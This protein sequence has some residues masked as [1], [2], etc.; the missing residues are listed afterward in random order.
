MNIKEVV[1]IEDATDY[2][3][4]YNLLLDAARGSFAE[5]VNGDDKSE[6]ERIEKV[7]KESFNEFA[8]DAFNMGR[9]YE[10]SKVGNKNA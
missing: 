6:I 7:F 2:S 10:K 1:T 9:E 8:T 5:I 4:L 3:G